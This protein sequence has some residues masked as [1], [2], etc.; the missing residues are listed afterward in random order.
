M[1]EVSGRAFL[2]ITAKPNTVIFLSVTSST[3]LLNQ[4]T[5]LI[6]FPLTTS[7]RGK[8]PK[9][10]I[11]A[12]KHWNFQWLLFS[13]SLSLSFLVF[14]DLPRTFFNSQFLIGS[15]SEGWWGTFRRHCFQ[16][17]ESLQTTH[18]LTEMQQENYW[19]RE[20]LLKW[21]DLRPVSSIW[22]DHVSGMCSWSGA[23]LLVL[24]KNGPVIITNSFKLCE[25]WMNGVSKVWKA[26]CI[27]YK[28]YYFSSPA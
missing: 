14:L 8:Y 26:L 6:T 25:N 16:R 11:P 27:F 22:S 9:G 20:R 5:L 3:T 18:L 7:S 10:L 28:I 1:S 24:C 21:I 12:G 2:R 15:R 13:T 17:W 19:I 4:V 23:Q